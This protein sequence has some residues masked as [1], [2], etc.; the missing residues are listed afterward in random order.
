M[1]KILK[2]NNKILMLR[3]RVGGFDPI[4]KINP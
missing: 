4:A 3:L 2:P 1:D